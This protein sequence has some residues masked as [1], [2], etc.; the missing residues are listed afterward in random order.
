MNIKALITTLVLGSSS[1]AL[2]DTTFTASAHA[3]WSLGTPGSSQ[4]HRD[5]HR[6]VHSPTWTVDYRRNDTVRRPVVYPQTSYLDS[7][8]DPRNSTV[9]A[10]TSEYKGQ[11]FNMPVGRNWY[12]R[13]SWFSITEP[14]RIDSGR[15]FITIGASAGRF[16][17]LMLQQVAGSSYIKQ[18]VVRFANGEEMVVRGI[19]Q[20]LNRNNRNVVIDLKGQN[21]Q[22]GG[23]VVYGS[24]SAR[25]AYKVMG[26]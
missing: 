12:Q 10:N 13:P 6:D 14:T 5:I 16:D 26:R 1:A 11:I 2:A 23:I 25:S 3:S 4:V 7:C 24:T 21:R 15:Q 8:V 18:V 20:Q 17:Q 9:G 22:I 19:D